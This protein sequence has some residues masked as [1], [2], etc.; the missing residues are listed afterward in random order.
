MLS[1]EGKECLLAIL[2]R[3]DIFGEQCLAGLG[4]RL[5]TATAMEET[6]LKLIPSS[7]FFL[8]L[9]C[10]S[11]MEGFVRYLA[12]RIA[13]QREAITNLVTVYSEHR[14][15]KILLQLASKLGRKNQYS[16]C[17]EHRISHEELARMVGT[18][19][20]RVS[21]FMQRFRALGLIEMSIEHFIVV[22]EG[23]LAQYLARAD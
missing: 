20:P 3:G 22:K 18:T 13:D 2:T 15:G 11:L 10:G 14:L 8:R 12:L 9:G 21:E 4:G 16:V 17:I 1:P 19:R 23:R 6:V 7:K 5:E